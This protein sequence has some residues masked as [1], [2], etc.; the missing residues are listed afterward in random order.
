[1]QWG[2]LALLALLPLLHGDSSITQVSP[3]QNDVAKQ[4]EINKKS[5][6]NL[7]LNSNP[8]FVEELSEETIKGDPTGKAS[9][10]NTGKPDKKLEVS[11]EYAI[12]EHSI[13]YNW[14]YNE[15]FTW[16][17]SGQSIAEYNEE[18][19][20]D[21]SLGMTVVNTTSTKTVS[22]VTTEPTPIP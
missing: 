18:V 15:D 16:E 11:R 17:F 14:E 9:T 7:D 19:T 2:I 10:E 12:W 21:S 3:A 20:D 13:D 6:L 5:S 1:M 4:E 8:E 22:V